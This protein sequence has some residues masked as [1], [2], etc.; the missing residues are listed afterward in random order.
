[1]DETPE[2]NTM[3]RLLPGTIDSDIHPSVPSIEALLPYMDDHWRDM[4]ITRGVDELNTISYPL[5]SPLTCRPD[6]RPPAGRPA[7]DLATVQREALDGFGTSIAI[8][9]RPAAPTHTPP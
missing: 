6:W 5:H 8:A 1:M 7:A 3:T 4:A 2:T 9:T